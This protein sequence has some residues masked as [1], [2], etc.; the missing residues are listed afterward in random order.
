MRKNRTAATLRSNMESI[1]EVWQ[2]D[3]QFF[4]AA[5]NSRCLPHTPIERLVGIRTTEIDVLQ[6]G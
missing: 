2:P 4:K 1:K 6:T 5:I 3:K